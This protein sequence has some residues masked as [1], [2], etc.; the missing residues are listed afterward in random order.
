VPI[1]KKDAGR[2]F[3]RV[4]PVLSIV[5]FVILLT[6][7]VAVGFGADPSSFCGGG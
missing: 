4:G 1:S 7:G 3:A 6:V 5:S 2:N